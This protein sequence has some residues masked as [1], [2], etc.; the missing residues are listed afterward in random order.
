M[1]KTKANNY[2]GSKCEYQVGK[3]I[4]S[5]CFFFSLVL[6]MTEIG[7]NVDSLGYNTTAN[8]L[9][10]VVSIKKDGDFYS[11]RL[12]KCTSDSLNLSCSCNNSGKILLFYAF[13]TVDSKLLS[14][15]LLETCKELDIYGK[16]RVSQ[17]GF[18]C[19]LGGNDAEIDMFMTALLMFLKRP[20][21]DTL[22]FKKKFFKPTPG[23]KHSFDGLSVKI[24][25]KLFP[26]GNVNRVTI[27]DYVNKPE[28]VLSPP[29][30]HRA[31]QSLTEEDVVLDLR[32]YYETRMVYLNL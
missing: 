31:V 17:E 4:N 8:T 22:Q 9:I 32:N 23:C 12:P 5:D 11:R 14:S 16:L 13:Q 21:L 28:N 1:S 30:F 19:T 18:N 25:S 20:E 10:P 6:R 15:F 24:V 29:E 7:R 3:K 26:I 2:M 27:N